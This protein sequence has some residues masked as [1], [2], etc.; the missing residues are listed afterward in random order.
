[1]KNPF[2]E[3][4]IVAN[5]VFLVLATVFV[6]LR[7]TSRIFI[8][9][10][11]TAPDYVMLIGWILLV[12]IT[13]VNI[14]GASKGLGLFAGVLQSWR[15]PLARAEYAFPVL[16]YPAVTAIKSSILLF[17]LTLAKGQFLFRVVVLVT[18][19]IVILFGL[20]LTLVNLF[21]CRPL[22]AS[23]LIET[24]PGTYCIDIVALYISSAPINILT[25]VAIFFL[26]MPILWNIRLPRR[27]KVILLLTFGAGIFVIVISIL[28]TEFLL[29]AAVERAIKPQPPSV[30]DLSC[31][32]STPIYSL[33]THGLVGTDYDAY[34]FLW[35]T[36]ELSLGIMCGC[37]PSLK[38]LVSRI[39]PWVLHTTE[40]TTRSSDTGTSLVH[41]PGRDNNQ[42][43]ETD[44][45]AGIA[46]PENLESAASGPE[47]AP[48]STPSQPWFD[49]VVLTSS[50]NMLGMSGRESIFP[51]TVICVIFFLWGF[52]YG[53]TSTFWLQFQHA[54][55]SK[56]DVT[57]ALHASY[58]GGYVFG[59]ILLARPILNYSGFKIALVTGISIFW[60]GMLSFWPATVLVSLPAILVAMFIAGLGV[61]VV[62][63]TA[64]LFTTLCG[65]SGRGEMRLSIAK[66]IEAIG[67]TASTILSDKVFFTNVVS[68]PGLID[69]QWIFLVLAIVPLLLAFAYTFVSLPEV[70]SD[71]LRDRA[72]CRERFTCS[73][74][75]EV[76]VMWITLILGFLAQFCSIGGEE[77]FR[78][79]FRLFVI[80][81]EPNPRP[82]LYG[83]V[84]I[85]NAASAAGFLFTALL[86]YFLKPRWILLGLYLCA[87]LFSALSIVTNS[88]AGIAMAILL[89]F[90]S[91]GISPIIFAICLRGMGRHTKTA[92]AFLT[93]AVSGG[94]I[95]PFVRNS[96]SKAHG[97]RY[98][99]YLDVALFSAG[100]LFAV[101]LNIV[102]GARVQTN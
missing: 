86:L 6:G 58:F 31:K 23:F 83:F 51:L 64:N 21:P 48:S 41:R 98:G 20:S 28:R 22:S 50:R 44:T 78:T 3:A 70:S 12:G 91:A 77:A 52:A 7:F 99:Y 47:N 9:R 25:D 87:I 37:V 79:N 73:R 100:S 102:T 69:V 63:T 56:V 97:Y 95:F 15:R 82:P 61:S 68:A 36:V 14:Y 74:I 29:H 85:S 10:R 88:Y 30:H 4:V 67:V 32:L 42:V 40:E 1:M 17:Y 55:R 59:P 34:V 75:S 96:M 72:H 101:Y 81:N 38:P 8:S 43:I 16:Y 93:T 66:G 49:F 90:F 35:S 53:I 26:P 11:A 13:A 2:G 60:F 19:G 57:F 71:E 80:F 33:C 84:A 24:P 89:S 92:A 62:E 27:Q 18:F 39:L 65:P 46:V 5:I 76:R 45:T 94:A 54:T